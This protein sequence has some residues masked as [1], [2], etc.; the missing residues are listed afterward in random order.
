LITLRKN[1]TCAVIPFFNE[2]DFIAEVIKKTLK[3]V[4]LVIAVDD[5]SK[6]NSLNLIKKIDNVEIIILDKNYGKG[7][8]LKAGFSLA[9]ELDFDIIL[10]LDADLQ[11]DPEF[12]PVFL[13]A[14]KKCDLVIGNRL[15]D[16]KSMPYHRILSNYLTSFLL[17]LKLKKIIKDSQCGYRAYKKK[18]LQKISIHSSGFEAE[19]EIIVRAVREKFSIGFVDI[20]TIYGNEKSKMK[21]FQA[22]KGFLKILFM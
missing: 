3:Y 10:T 2:E 17:S 18:V 9:I 8:A 14:I 22:I 16:L 11:H 7:T 19:S 20:P 13:D 4:D 6:D 1:N 12:I 15:S 5:G 21:S